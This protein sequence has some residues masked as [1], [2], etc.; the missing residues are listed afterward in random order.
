MKKK[1]IIRMSNNLGN[2]MF[3][4]ASALSFSRQM[5]R[6]LLIDNESSYLLKKNSHTRFSLDFFN[7]SSKIAP[8]SLKFTGQIGHLKRKLLK[9]LNILKLRKTFYL[10]NKNNDK[11]TFYD[12]SFLDKRYSDNLF[13][14]GYFE[15]EKYFI[16]YANDI[17]KEFV[18]KNKSK[19]LDH[20]LYKKIKNTHSICV[21]IRQNRFSGGKN[22]ISIEDENKSKQFSEEQSN[23]IKNCMKIFKQK[24]PNAKFFLWSNSYNDLSKY[25]PTNELNIVSTNKTDLDFFLMTQAK[26]FIVVPSSFNWWG[27][28][29]SE[30]QE[31][32]VFRPSNSIFSNYKINN[33]DFWPKNWIEINYND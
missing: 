8:K 5:E 26:H 33:I 27:C 30:N 15:S 11:T 23:Y 3:M 22:R 9:K 1:L 32:I 2:Q 16:N 31:K 21:C 17:R 10:E 14:E 19:Y 29:L 12:D 7:I 24:I 20:P 18:L 25:L 4:Y 6:E 13:I 28:W